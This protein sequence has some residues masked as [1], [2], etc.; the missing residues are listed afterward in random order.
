MTNRGTLKNKKVE[1]PILKQ[2]SKVYLRCTCNIVECP[3]VNTCIKYI[4]KYL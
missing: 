1:I 2:N 3:N 4:V